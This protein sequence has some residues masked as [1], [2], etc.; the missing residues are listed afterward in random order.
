MWSYVSGQRRSSAKSFHAMISIGKKDLCDVIHMLKLPR[1]FFQ[2]SD[3]HILD[4]FIFKGKYFSKV[5]LKT[6]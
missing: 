2:C 1:H 5:L 6:V 3:E 4:I